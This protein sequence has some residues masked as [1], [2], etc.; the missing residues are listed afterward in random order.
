MNDNEQTV[1][2]MKRIKMLY[3]GGESDRAFALRC[4][5]PQ[6]TFSGYATGK[7]AIKIENAISV[8]ETTGASLDWILT[9]KGPIF[10]PGSN[11]TT[12]HQQAGASAAQ[13][14]HNSTAT[15]TTNGTEGLNL[16]PLEHEIISLLRELGPVAARGVKGMLEKRLEEERE[17]WNR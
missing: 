16:S 3:K 10:K 9:G 1:E 4:G 6:T 2:I 12:A 15:L 8:S 7:R 5:I 13:A 11:G 17:S 14:T